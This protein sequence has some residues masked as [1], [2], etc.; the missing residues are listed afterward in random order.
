MLEGINNWN[1]HLPLLLL[2][3]EN[4]TGYILELGMGNGSTPFLHEYCEVNNRK[5]ASYENNINYVNQ[6]KKLENENHFIFHIEDWRELKTGKKK[7]GVVL[8][9]HAPAEQRHIDAI[10][11][12]DKA[13]IVVVHDCEHE[14]LSYDVYHIEKIAKEFKYRLDL[15]IKPHPAK[16]VMF[17][18][19]ID[20]SKLTIPEFQY[21]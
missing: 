5:L 12:K 14:G 4:T 9:D 10:A 8:I 21:Y 18:N 17:S 13:E 19:K 15:K 6:F 20:V 1:N 2:A 7:I 11:L 3:L 16:T